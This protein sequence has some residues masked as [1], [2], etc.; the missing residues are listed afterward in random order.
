MELWVDNLADFRC[1][2][3]K[4]GQPLVGLAPFRSREPER[5]GGFENV[6]FRLRWEAF[7]VLTRLLNR[8]AKVGLAD[9]VVPRKDGRGP[10]AGY[11]PS[12]VWIYASSYHV[13]D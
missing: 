10:M 3:K 8:V 2:I 4:K 9:D 13:A 1:G 7:D 6:D 12:H 5:S 11:L